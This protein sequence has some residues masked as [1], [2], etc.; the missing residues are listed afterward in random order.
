MTSKTTGSTS[1]PMAELAAVL[2][3]ERKFRFVGQLTRQDWLRW[4]PTA[5]AYLRKGG[6]G[7]LLDLLDVKE[8]RVVSSLLKKPLLEVERMAN[9]EF[10]QAM[11]EALLPADAHEVLSSLQRI[12]MAASA[13]TRA[14]LCDFLGAFELVLTD[15]PAR[16]TPPATLP[17]WVLVHRERGPKLQP[18]WKGPCRVITQADERGVVELENIVKKERFRTHVSKLRPFRGATDDSA[19]LMRLAELDDDEYEIEKIVAH[20]PPNLSGP[21]KAWIFQVRWVGYGEDFDEWVPYADLAET[22][23]LQEYLAD[24]NKHFTGAM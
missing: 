24:R 18:P 19:A 14:N 8:H 5:R 21:K 6:K 15:L 1:V 16:I 2:L 23:K 20:H 11:G 22:E 9:D 7:L 13:D 12:K 17:T 4:V 10:L 3:D